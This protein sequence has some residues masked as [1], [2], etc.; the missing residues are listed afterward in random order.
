MTTARRGAE[1]WDE[2]ERW[3]I[4]AP[5][6]P[7]AFGADDGDWGGYGG[8]WSGSTSVAQPSA[9]PPPAPM[10]GARADYTRYRALS[11]LPGAAGQTASEAATG[12]SGRRMSEE[13]RDMRETDREQSGAA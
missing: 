1:P 10:G 5:A 9:A 3:M 4:E 2:N 7:E 13:L 8:G 11:A 12:E 6:E